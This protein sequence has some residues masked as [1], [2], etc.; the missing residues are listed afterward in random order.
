MLCFD[1]GTG[2]D[3]EE[4]EVREWA[5][6]DGWMRLPV[7][8]RRVGIVAAMDVFGGGPYLNPAPVSTFRCAE[9]GESPFPKNPIT[10]GLH[11]PHLPDPPCSASARTGWRGAGTGVLFCR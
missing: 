10:G 2:N 6:R 3:P 4:Q 5:N 8:G 9:C 7:V 1:F 11:R